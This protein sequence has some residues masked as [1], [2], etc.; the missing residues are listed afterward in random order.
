MNRR[1]Q[2]DTITMTS[3]EMSSLG[4]YYHYDEAD[5]ST[6]TALIF[7]PADTPYANCPLFFSVKVPKD[8]PFASPIVIMLTS[9]GITRFHP[10]LYVNGKVCLSILGT[11][12]GPSW[13]STLNIGSV[14]KSIVSLLDKNP[15]T[16]EPGWESY[17]ESHPTARAYAEWVEYHLLQHT[18]K[19]YA[20]Y[21]DGK[22]PLW[23]KFAQV[24]D[25]V[26][27]AHLQKIGERVKAKS[28]EPMKKY[29]SIPYGMHGMIRWKD[30]SARL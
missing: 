8:Y 14:F 1:L 4:I 20:L 25:E 2:R 7:G 19:E 27:P 24:I 9:D 5:I 3:D 23:S 12:T 21:K 10:N 15:M 22:N 11:Y 17:E 28:D 16:N 26:W 6:G 13:T 30:L 29:T 18:L